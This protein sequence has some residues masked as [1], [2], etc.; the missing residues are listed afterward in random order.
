MATSPPARSSRVSLAL[1][2]SMVVFLAGLGFFV[3]TR[4]ASGRPDVTPASSGLAVATPRPASEPP[5]ESTAPTATSTA[6]PTPTATPGP[7]LEQL[8]GQKLLIRMD[9]LTPSASLLERVRNGEVGGVV[10]F[11]FNV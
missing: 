4:Y 6:E 7:P 1:V 8:V 3:G 2:G 9:G 11:G 5:S 10:L